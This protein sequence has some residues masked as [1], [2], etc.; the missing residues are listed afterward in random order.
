VADHLYAHGLPRGQI[1]TEWQLGELGLELIEV[2]RLERPQADADVLGEVTSEANSKQFL[3]LSANLHAPFGQL[4]GKAQ[5]LHLFLQQL[6]QAQGALKKK[7]ITREYSGHEDVGAFE[8][9][10][11]G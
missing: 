8:W 5:L 4:A 7:S 9:W 1:R 3:E 10:G 6:F 11:R 2:A